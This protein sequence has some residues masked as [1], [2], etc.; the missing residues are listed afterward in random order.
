MT[1]CVDH[2]T[3]AYSFLEYVPGGSIGSCLRKYG[4]FSDNVA[5][6]FTAQI[7]EGLEYLHSKNILHRV[8]FVVV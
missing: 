3:L 7:L 8:C 2:G 6:S 1:K 5:R 4:K